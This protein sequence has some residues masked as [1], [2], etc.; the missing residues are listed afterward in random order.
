MAARDRFGRRHTL[1][2]RWIPALALLLGVGPSVAAGQAVHNVRADADERGEG[3][4]ARV[5]PGGR[6]RFEPW[7]GVLWDAYRNE[8]GSGAPAWLGAARFGYEM[9][10]GFGPGFR[11]VAEIARAEVEEA[12]RAVVG[13]SLEVD[14][15]SRWWLTTAGVEWDVRGG[16]TGLTLEAQGGA[17]WITLEVTGG[18]SIPAGTPGTTARAEAEPYPTA[19][20]GL[21]AWRHLSPTLQLRLRVEDVVTDLFDAMEHSPALGVGVR[22]LFE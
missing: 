6:F 13:D 5:I 3:T 21:S 1:I 2:A 15:A 16:W 18:D 8:G 20:V 10:N 22:F 7:A 11:L 19:R 17:A 9:G 12:G 4:V 14:F